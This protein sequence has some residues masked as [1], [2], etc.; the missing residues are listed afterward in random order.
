MNPHKIIKFAAISGTIAVAFG[1]FG[2]HILR[3]NLSDERSDI[4][5]TAVRYQ[6]Y[7]TLALIGIAASGN[8]LHV[9]F[10]RTSALLFQT[11]IIIFSG[12]LY[13]L[14]ISELLFGSYL[15]W[16]GG[17]TPLGGVCL[18]AGWIFLLISVMKHNS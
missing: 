5:E 15:S 10:M 2:A 3:E 12:S 9:K 16:L 7:H 17:I 1:A 11:G 14:S 6:F 8:Y 13:M 18:I 4:F